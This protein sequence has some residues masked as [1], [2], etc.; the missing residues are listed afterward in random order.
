MYEICDQARHLL[1][2]A[3]T[4]EAAEDA[5]NT[6]TAEQQ[7]GTWTITDTTTGEVVATLAR[8]GR[9]AEPHPTVID[10]MRAVAG[11]RQA[12]GRHQHAAGRAVRR[13]RA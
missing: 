12:A 11:Q 3:A 8:A 7:A 6:L 13:P 5:L 4:F 10:Q 2:Q 9:P 1:A